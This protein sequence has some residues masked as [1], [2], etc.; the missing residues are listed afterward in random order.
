MDILSWL[1]WLLAKVLGVLWAL[2]WLL[3]GGWVSTLAQIAV[4]A[5]AIFAYK[6]GWRRAPHE[7]ASRIVPLARMLW[8]WLRGREGAAA[9]ASPARTAQAPPGYAARPSQ[10][11]QP[12]DVNISTLLNLLLLS[13]LGLL[14]LL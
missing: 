13:G 4:I 7:L 14:A 11:R 8:G 12:G 6:Y 3:L 10:R 9:A 5:F 1:W 2:V